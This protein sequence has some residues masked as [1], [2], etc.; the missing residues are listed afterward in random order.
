MWIINLL[1]ESI[2]KCLLTFSA[3]VNIAAPGRE[4][5]IFCEV[6]DADITEEQAGV[7]VMSKKSEKS[8]KVKQS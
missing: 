4:L 7:T 5:P 3:G 6:N 2:G 8:K 1:P